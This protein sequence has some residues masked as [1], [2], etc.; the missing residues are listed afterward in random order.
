LAANWDFKNSPV[1]NQRAKDSLP[2][3]KKIRINKMGEAYAPAF[4][5]DFVELT[6]HIIGGNGVKKGWLSFN[7]DEAQ[8]ILSGYFGG[9]YTTISQTIDSAYKSILP[10]ED[11]KMRDTPF[12]R[13]YTPESDLSPVGQGE[14]SMY[15]KVRKKISGNSD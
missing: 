2:G 8:H 11:V 12:R 4:L 14:E 5:V 9:L 1:Y 6:D 13:F 7:P 10:D 15:R 3:Y